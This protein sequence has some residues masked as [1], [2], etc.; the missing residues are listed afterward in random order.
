MTVTKKSL[1][2]MWLTYTKPVSPI[3][4][5]LGRVNNKNNL[6]LTKQMRLGACNQVP[7]FSCLFSSSNEAMRLSPPA[8]AGVE[9]GACMKNNMYAWNWK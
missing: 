1:A 9:E 5:L 4:A 7:F 3:F 6:S 8:A 2:G